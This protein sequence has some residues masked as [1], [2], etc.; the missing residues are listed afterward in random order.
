LWLLVYGVAV[1][2]FTKTI[3]ECAQSLLSEILRSSKFSEIFFVSR[4]HFI[5]LFRSRHLSLDEDIDLLVLFAFLHTP[6]A[7]LSGE[8]S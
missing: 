3:D 8:K 2:T 4:G 1:S 7:A 5:Y 6:A